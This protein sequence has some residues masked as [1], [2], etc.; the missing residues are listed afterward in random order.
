MSVS[1]GP[2]RSAIPGLPTSVTEAAPDDDFN[3]TPLSD[4]EL[5][6]ERDRL[7]T[8]LDELTVNEG[9]TPVTSQMLVNIDK[10]IDRITD[11]L[12]HRALSRHPAF[13]GP[14]TRQRYRSF[15]R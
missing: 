9:T 5:I 11:E 7:R 4:L 10:Q 3:V 13:T 12:T 1:P 2:V 8:Q 15:V 14:T 6:L